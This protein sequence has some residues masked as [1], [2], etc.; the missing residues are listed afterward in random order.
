MQLRSILLFAFTG[1][2]FGQQALKDALG[3]TE[4]QVWRLRQEKSAPV[5]QLGGA[6]AGRRPGVP[7]AIP[8]DYSAALQVALQ[9]P[10]LDASQQNKLAEIVKVL[11]RWNMASE[12]IVL[13]LINLQQWPGTM[14]CFSPHRSEFGLSDS[15]QREIHQL[16]EPLKKAIAQKEEE[17]LKLALISRLRADSAEVVQVDADISRLRLEWT[18]EPLRGQIKAVL[19]DA[20]KAKLA[21]FEAGLQLV[22]EAIEMKVIPIPPK[23]EPLCM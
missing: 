19:N 9:N 22:R 1:T 23:G 3:L 14:Q 21:E 16:H 8:I 6:A 5:I 17:R 11:D 7:A 20:Q 18:A 13:G 12:A 10:I 4:M 15:Q 2:V